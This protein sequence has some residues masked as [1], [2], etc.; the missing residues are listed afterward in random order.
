MNA[1][2]QIGRERKARAIAHRI[3][4]DVP[5]EHRTRTDLPRV[6]ALATHEERAAVAEAAGRKAPSPETWNRVTQLIADRVAE[7]RHWL[8]L[9]ERTA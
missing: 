1:Y 5:R 8:S 7:E 3:W 9:D 6:V 4:A 2:E